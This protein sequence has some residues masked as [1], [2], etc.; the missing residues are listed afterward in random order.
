MQTPPLQASWIMR[1]E[2][3]ARGE[4]SSIPGTKTE[5][6]AEPGMLVQT[7]ASASPEAETESPRVSGVPMLCSHSGSLR[8]DSPSLV[9]F[10]PAPCIANV[11]AG[12]ATS[13]TRKDFIVRLFQHYHATA[14][15]ENKG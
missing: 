11:A 13:N 4:T 15:E 2:F 9:R 7:A 1:H 10:R 12:T 3:G 8:R 6:I 5:F 14:E